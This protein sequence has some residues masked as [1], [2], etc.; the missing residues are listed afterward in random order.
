MFNCGCEVETVSVNFKNSVGFLRVAE[1]QTPH[2]DKTARAFL[3]IDEDIKRIEL[4]VGDELDSL[5]LYIAEINKW[6]AAPPT[7]RFFG[8]I[9]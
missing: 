7:P 3:A 2:I 4:Y 8:E 6:V 9:K 5:I 1:G